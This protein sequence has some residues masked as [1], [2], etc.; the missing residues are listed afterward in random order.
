MDRNNDELYMWRALVAFALSDHRFSLEEQTILSHH[1]TSANLNR[2]EKLILKRDM[3][4]PQNVAYF[5]EKIKSDKLK[6]RF[7]ELARTL[8]WCD[9]DITRQEKEI[10]KRVRCFKV[11]DE[12]EI[13]KY[14]GTAEFIKQYENIFFMNDNVPN[15]YEVVA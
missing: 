6:K 12:M 4:K 7:C 9:G 14:S 2:E 3:T 13:L 5:Y 11:H 15:L 8:V 10:L 1:L